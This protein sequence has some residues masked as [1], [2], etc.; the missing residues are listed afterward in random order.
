ML[1]EDVVVEVLERGRGSDAH[2]VREETAVSVEHA[3]RLDRA[4]RTRQRQHQHRTQPL[5]ERL[6]LNVRLQTS[7]HFARSTKL[8]Y[9][10][11]VFLYRAPT[12]VF[13]PC[14]LGSREF[15][16]G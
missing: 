4:A 6:R 13:E 14:H 10:G 7:D 9:G 1:T 11:G 5:A 16:L 3:E 8:D 12:E 2:L 15:L